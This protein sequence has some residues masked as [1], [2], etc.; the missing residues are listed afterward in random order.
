MIN[1]VDDGGNGEIE[2]D[3][4]LQ[5]MNDQMQKQELDEELIAAFKFFGANSVDDEVDF[6]TLNRA[7]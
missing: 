3:E 7:L 6:E 4:F 5:L 1:A 2:M